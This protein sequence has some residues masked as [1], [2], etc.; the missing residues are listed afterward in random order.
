MH[1]NIKAMMYIY[2][3]SVATHSPVGISSSVFPG[4]TQTL[5]LA[6]VSQTPSCSHT[7]A[8]SHSVSMGTEKK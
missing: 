6:S 7:D 3:L 2:V 1:I 5:T 8:S 4:H